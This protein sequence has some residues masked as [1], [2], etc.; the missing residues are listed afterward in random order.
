MGFKSFSI[1][2]ELDLE[3][4]KIFLTDS[5]GIAVFRG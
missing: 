1:S 4:S 2:E 3:Q 5:D